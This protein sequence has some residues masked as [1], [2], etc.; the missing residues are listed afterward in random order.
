MKICISLLVIFTVFLHAPAFG[1]DQYWKWTHGNERGTPNFKLVKYPIKH[2]LKHHTKK[3]R[4][5]LW[6][7]NQKYYY[8]HYRKSIP[9]SELVSVHVKH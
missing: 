9:T 7:R 2:H 1:Q 8:S 4:E 5:P 3:Y 6:L